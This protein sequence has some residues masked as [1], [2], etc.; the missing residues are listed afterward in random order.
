[1]PELFAGNKLRWEEKDNL[2][3][4][5]MNDPPENKMNAT[6]FK[7][8]GHIANKII[9]KSK[10]SA[11]IITGSGRHFSSG[12]ELDDLYKVVEHKKT[13]ALIDNYSVFRKLN[14]LQVPVIA[15]IR[16][17][18]IGAGFELALH[19]HFRLCAEDAILAL[20]E[21]GFGIIPGLD[22][23]SK[24]LELSGKAKAMELVLTGKHFNASDAIKWQLIDRIFQKK[25]VFEK[26]IELARLSAVNYRKYNKK[27]YLKKL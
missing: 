3:F 15:A 10:V 13:D 19:C 6:F 24:M 21:S 11:I 26:A 20:P 1:M 22:G 16:G 27:N 14:E 7:E 2:G 9:P 18:C 12:A 25:V 8:L 5:N 4:I 23:I 17:V